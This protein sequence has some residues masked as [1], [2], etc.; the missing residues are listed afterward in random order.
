MLLIVCYAG[1]ISSS[2]IICAFQSNGHK[3]IFLDLKNCIPHTP[4]TMKVYGSCLQSDN[5]A[6]FTVNCQFTLTCDI[7]VDKSSSL[8]NNS[9]LCDFF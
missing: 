6:S 3:S 7:S 1:Y 4:I 9:R 8:G 2:R 5:I